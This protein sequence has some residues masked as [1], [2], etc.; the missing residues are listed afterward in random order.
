MELSQKRQDM[1]KAAKLYYFG[2]MPQDEIAEMMGISRP[3]VS[4]L[5]TEARQ[6]GV[7]K[8]SVSEPDDS[9][10]ETTRRIRETFGLR[11]VIIVPS[12]ANEDIAK[13]NVGRAASDFL[14]ENIRPESKIG[15]SWGTTLATFAREF[16][17]K[18]P[19]PHA[20][21]VQM[22]GGTYSQSLNIDGRE[23]VKT[24]S[25]KLQCRSSILHAPLL[26]HNPTLRD[27][28]MQ[29]PAVMEHFEHI[30]TLDMAF[31]GIGHAG[32]DAVAVRANYIAEEEVR[33]LEAMGMVGDVC[34]HY[35]TADGEVPETFLTSR[36]VGITP[37]QLRSIPLV[38][39]LCVGH[40]KAEPILAVLRGHY[41]NCL[42]IDEVAAISLLAAMN[43]D[44]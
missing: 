3:K 6:I 18:E 22:I 37:Q 26:V 39:G 8:V 7:V 28:L 1:I 10:E 24:I 5:L 4:R 34:G 25:G 21:V 27:L 13:A 9:L 41:I 20:R 33:K 14:N 43:A 2:N 16:R 19:C 44:G 11:R 35:I 17:A 38:A 32:R 42:I 30:R 40:K 31:I 36:V 12:G 23:L 29:E 15:I